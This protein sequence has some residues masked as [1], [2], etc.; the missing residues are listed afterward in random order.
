ML[1]WLQTLFA[2]VIAIT[3]M[4][5]LILWHNGRFLRM[6]NDVQIQ[7]L[8][9]Q[10]WAIEGRCTLY[11]SIR[12]S[13]LYFYFLTCSWSIAITESWHGPLPWGSKCKATR[14]FDRSIFNWR[15]PII[16]FYICQLGTKLLGASRHSVVAWVR[17]PSW[18][19]YITSKYTLARKTLEGMCMHIGSL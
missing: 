12:R 1:Q 4:I 13:G 15:R 16:V 19:P 14:V 18:Q 3:A 8:P 5:M 9:S 11:A 6:P 7:S 17:L 10:I 2:Q